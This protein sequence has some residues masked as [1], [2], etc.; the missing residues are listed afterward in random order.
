MQMFLIHITY[1]FN[2]GKA[3]G[4]FIAAFLC[5]SNLGLLTFDSQSQM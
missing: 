2:I 4:N 5:T 3:E 1:I